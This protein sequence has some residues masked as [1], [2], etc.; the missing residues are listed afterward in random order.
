MAASCVTPSTRNASAAL[1]DTTRRLGRISSG[2]LDLRFEMF[3][4]EDEPG[5]FEL[6][7]P[8][9][10]RSP[11][12]LPVAQLE[13]TRFDGQD[14]ETSGTFVSTGRRAYVVRKGRAKRLDDEAI[15]ATGIARLVRT[16]DEPDGLGHLAVDD[17]IAGEPEVSAG[18]LVGGDD[19][20]KISVDLDAGELLD[21]L[22]AIGRG[23][24]GGAAGRLQPLS[25][26]ERARVTRAVS[27]AT[28]EAWTGKEDRLLRKLVITVAFTSP[29][30][31]LAREVDM[32]SGATIK[33]EAA[34]TDVNERVVV[35]DPN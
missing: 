9:S 1:T 12:R 10:L 19:T 6:E 24:G 11:G 13:H 15:A 18:G 14:V 34:I 31:K 20:D 4:R 8:F 21:G 22:V 16:D 3:V 29:N 25:A 2:T 27:R 35:E 28:L 30:E 33:L 7:G 5:G 23:L 26:S 17:W 32:F